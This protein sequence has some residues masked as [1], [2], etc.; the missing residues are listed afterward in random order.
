MSPLYYREPKAKPS[1]L[2]TNV[3]SN[4]QP[5]GAK[6]AFRGKL[7]PLTSKKIKPHRGESQSLAAATRNWAARM[8]GIAGQTARTHTVPLSF[9]RADPCLSV[10]LWTNQGR[11]AAS[12]QLE[13]SI[14][15]ILENVNL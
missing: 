4:G 8:R 12:P 15:C 14:Y 6:Q 10:H 3:S 5:P 11:K 9:N 1:L 7:C 2:L 13:K